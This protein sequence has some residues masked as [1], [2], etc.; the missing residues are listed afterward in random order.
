MTTLMAN[1]T[2]KAKRI[3]DRDS[4]MAA[5]HVSSR[6]WWGP[7]IGGRTGDSDGDGDG[8]K[9]GGGGRGGDG[10]EAFPVGGEG[11]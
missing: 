2:V 9:G 6:L 8:E 11:L 5:T 1:I 10:D 7:G 4:R 3:P